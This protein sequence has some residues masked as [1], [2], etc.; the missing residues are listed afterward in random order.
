MTS[1]VM[2]MGQTVLCRDVPFLV[3]HLV[4]FH[5][6][7]F[8]QEGYLLLLFAQEGYL[9]FLFAQEG[10]LL[11]LFAQEGYLLLLFLCLVF[12]TSSKFWDVSTGL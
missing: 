6:S 4:Y 12:S 2:L 1:L 9:L 3:L 5:V 11:L 10:Y 7:L 8:A